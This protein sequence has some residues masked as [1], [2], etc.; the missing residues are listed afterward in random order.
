MPLP[1]PLYSI[2]S[3]RSTQHSA[4]MWAIRRLVGDDIPGVIVGMAI[5][6]ATMAI[7][8]ATFE[9]AHQEVIY[10]T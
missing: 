5:A 8:I 3:A 6:I 2:P 9:A 10:H 7:A 1:I 4:R